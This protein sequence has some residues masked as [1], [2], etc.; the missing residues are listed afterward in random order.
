MVVIKPGVSQQWDDG[1]NSICLGFF[2]CMCVYVC[3]CVLADTN[4]FYS[5]S[6]KPSF[7][8]VYLTHN[9]LNCIQQLSAINIVGR[10]LQTRGKYK[11]NEQ[12]IFP[13]PTPRFEKNSTTISLVLSFP[14]IDFGLVMLRIIQTFVSF[15]LERSM[16]KVALTVCTPNATSQLIL[17]KPGVFLFIL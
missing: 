17:P 14:F 15:I 6:K 1:P 11:V 4:G 9:V 16:L 12:R 7:A 3:V 8:K 10:R 2:V 13:S 5:A